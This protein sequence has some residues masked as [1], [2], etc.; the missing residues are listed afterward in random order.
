MS[1]RATVFTRSEVGG[2]ESGETGDRNSMT[3]D[4]LPEEQGTIIKPLFEKAE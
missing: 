3:R 4:F 2:P 1:H